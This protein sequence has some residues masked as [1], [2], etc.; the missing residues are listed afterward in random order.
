MQLKTDTILFSSSTSMSSVSQLS[1]PSMD[2]PNSV[3]A[4][5]AV[6]RGFKQLGFVLTYGS[7]VAG[8]CLQ[9]TTGE[10]CSF[11]HDCFCSSGNLKL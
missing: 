5:E 2:F 6:V 10:S 3:S 11:V 7:N 1:S 4:T 9:S 8:L